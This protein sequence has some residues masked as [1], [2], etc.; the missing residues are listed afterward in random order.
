VF[1]FREREEKTLKTPS[2]NPAD[3][4]PQN[5]KSLL[6]QTRLKKTVFFRGLLGVFFDAFKAYAT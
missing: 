2:L 1:R 3:F 4:L 6:S 5:L